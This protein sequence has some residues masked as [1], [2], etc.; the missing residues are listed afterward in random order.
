MINVTT[1]EPPVYSMSV[2]IVF[3][4]VYFNTLGIERFYYNYSNIFIELPSA[5]YTNMLPSQKCSK[6][7]SISIKCKISILLIYS[8]VVCSYIETLYAPGFLP[9]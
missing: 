1:L 2:S 4:L 7:L 5:L 9:A 8:T 3:L 6:D